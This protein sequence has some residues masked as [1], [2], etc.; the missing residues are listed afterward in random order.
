MRHNATSALRKVLIL[1]LSIIYVQG[2]AQDKGA[3]V[4]R[5][6]IGSYNLANDELNEYVVQMKA[7]QIMHTA[8]R[9]GASTT[10]GKINKDS[11]KPFEQYVNTYDYSM[12][13]LK[14]KQS[15]DYSYV[16]VYMT[17]GDYQEAYWNDAP[18][19]EAGKFYADV[20]KL[21]EET[22]QATASK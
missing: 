15:K 14:Y 10:V 13:M 7:G 8:D 2:F 12:F 20:M 22:R 6:V 5:I 16:R 3:Q 17:N 18:G 11:F 9:T 1:I 21:I 19:P 4:D